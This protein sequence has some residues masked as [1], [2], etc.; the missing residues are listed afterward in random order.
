V[1]ETISLKKKTETH[2]TTL[3]FGILIIVITVLLCI[4]IFNPNEWLEA[5][6]NNIYYIGIGNNPLWAI[7][8]DNIPWFLSKIPIVKPFRIVPINLKWQEWVDGKH[9]IEEKLGNTI[10]QNK[11][12][13]R[14]FKNIIEFKSDESGFIGQREEWVYSLRKLEYVSYAVEVNSSDG[15]TLTL[16]LSFYLR[17]TDF[18]KV[19]KR[20]IFKMMGKEAANTAI[21]PWANG[22]T[23]GDIK[24]TNVDLV[25]DPTCGIIIQGTDLVTYLDQ[26][27]F[28]KV[29]VAIDSTFLS[30]LEGEGVLEIF[31]LRQKESKEAQNEKN[32]QAFAK[33]RMTQRTIEK[34][35]ADQETKI[36]SERVK[37]ATTAVKDLMILN[38]AGEGYVA[39][40]RPNVMVEVKS[41]DNSAVNDLIKGFADVMPKTN[42][43]ASSRK[44]KKEAES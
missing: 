39:K 27:H 21:E 24:D 38:Y 23:F 9:R 10:G 32:A 29:G 40:Q 31:K 12:D 18:M 41:G 19:V 33:T 34:A 42:D 17:L 30:I 8:G 5:A 25:T 15:F 28:D 36:M 20:P 35:D 11:M 26:K 22:K 4:W 13:E 16:I 2:M 7:D 3:I 1:N 44:F 37:E 14:K 6:P 43:T